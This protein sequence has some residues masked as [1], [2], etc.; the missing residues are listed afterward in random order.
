M[1]CA[2][3]A[4]SVQCEVCSACTLQSVCRMRCVQCACSASAVCVQCVHSGCSAC[5]IQ[6]VQ[7][8]VCAVCSV[9]SMQ[10]GWEMRGGRGGVFA[11]SLLGG[12]VYYRNETLQ[13]GK[14]S[15]RVDT[16]TQRNSAPGKMFITC[17][18]R[19]EEC[20]SHVDTKLCNGE[21]VHHMS[22]TGEE[23]PPHVCNGGR[24]P[25]HVCKGGEEFPSHFSPSAMHERPRAMER[26]GRSVAALSICR[27]TIAKPPP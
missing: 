4:G 3:Y 27:S 17:L 8:A 25:S 11:C 13:R 21:N 6:C 24:I 5:S 22:A 15:S 23:F 12:G 14:C 9:C 19:G 26:V 7:C 18:Q 2:M 16:V 20:S 10:C 1:H